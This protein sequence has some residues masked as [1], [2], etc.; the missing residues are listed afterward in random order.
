MEDNK[1]TPEQ[2]AK[3]EKKK[4]N[5]I[6]RDEFIQKYKRYII[7]GSVYLALVLIVLVLIIVSMATGPARITNSDG[8]VKYNY[9]NNDTDKVLIW[10]DEGSNKCKFEN[11]SVDGNQETI[12]YY[13]LEKKTSL[14]VYTDEVK[15]EFYAYFTIGRLYD[16]TPIAYKTFTREIG[17]ILGY[18]YNANNHKYHAIEDEISS[19]G[20][21]ITQS[22]TKDENGNAY[23]TQVEAAYD[24]NDYII[25][26]HD[27]NVSEST[28]N[29]E[30]D[31][32]NGVPYTLKR[33]T[34]GLHSAY[35][36]TNYASY[37]DIISKNKSETGTEYFYNVVN[38]YLVLYSA[39][40]VDNSTAEQKVK[41]SKI[42]LDDVTFYQMFKLDTSNTT[43]YDISRTSLSLNTTTTN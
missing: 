15:T 17:D 16:L 13:T 31:K 20:T 12:Y 29:E 9:N 21:T 36:Y 7:V 26:T 42:Y 19:D 34:S 8:W 23:M 38:E 28:I 2:L 41:I 4:E 14:T 35:E 43:N 1:S 22:E 39:T 11:G 40:K 18:E 6:K 37:N 30:I 5:K 33:N 32:E 3:Q 24:G 27:L 25:E 10:V